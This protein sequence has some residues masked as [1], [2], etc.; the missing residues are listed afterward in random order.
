MNLFSVS[1]CLVYLDFTYETVYRICFSQSI[2]VLIMPLRSVHVVTNGKI[3]FFQWV[4]NISMYFKISF[5]FIHQYCLH[6]LPVVSNVA[7]NM[8]FNIFCLVFS[9]SS[10][11]YPEIILLDHMVVPFLILQENSIRLSIAAITIHIPTNGA[12]GFPFLY[13]L[14]NTCYFLT[15]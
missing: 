6:I 2:A 1:M 12:Q 7:F 9:F 14:V 13:I 10:D 3:L 4:N 15:F 11:K 5:T 8:E